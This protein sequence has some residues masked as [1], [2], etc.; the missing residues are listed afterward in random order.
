MP[1]AALV[2]SPKCWPF[3]ALL[4]R[5][6]P[7]VAA[8]V[9]LPVVA[10]GLPAPAAAQIPPPNVRV[11]ALPTVDNEPSVAVHGNHVVAV[12]YQGFYLNAAGWA[13][14]TDGGS[15]WIQRGDFPKGTN[16]QAY[17]L[18]S[19]SVGPDGM[20]HAA[21]LF[22]AVYPSGGGFYTVATFR[23]T[24]AGST[25]TW[26]GPVYAIPDQNTLAVDYDAPWIAS[27]PQ[28]GN[29]YLVYTRWYFDNSINGQS[30]YEIYLVRS[31]DGGLTWSAPQALS[32][33]NCNGARAM[34]GPDRELYVVW[35]DLAGEQ[36]VGRKSSDFGVTFGAPFVVAPLREN[37]GL[38]PPGG[39]TNLVRVNPVRR[40]QYCPSANFPALAVD[41]STGPRRGTLYAAWAEYG[42][43][44]VAPAT[45]SVSDPEPNDSFAS[46]ARV[47]IGQDFGG[48][49]KSSDIPPYEADVDIYT[50]D[51]IAGT[52]VWL[53]GEITGTDFLTYPYRTE[54]GFLWCGD[55]TTSLTEL[56][57]VGFKES[58]VGPSV[59]TI[60][61]L[62]RTGRY[63]LQLQCCGY[64]YRF[65]LRRYE[66]TP[67][68]A[69]RDQRDLVL[70]SSSDGG[71]TW[72]PKVRVNDDPPGFD[73]AFP[74]VA[75]DPRGAVHVAWY[76]HREVPGCG[77]A[78][79]VRLASSLDGG[80]TFGPSRRV[81][82]QPSVSQALRVGDH[83]ALEAVGDRLYVLWAQQ[84]R[85][86]VDVYS[87]VITDAV[88]ATLVQRFS[89][90]AEAD[91]VRVRWETLGGLDLAGFRLY[92][93]LREEGPY[94]PLE[95]TLQPYQGETRFE[96]EDRAV[97][98]GSAYWYR[99]EAVGRD[100]ASLWAGPISV[101]V[102]PVAGRLA[103]Q[104]TA[105]NPFELSVTM[106][107]AV[108]KAGEGWVRLYD[109]AGH[110]VA[111]LHRG[112]LPPGLHTF[113][114]GGTNTR[115][116]PTPAGI[117]LLR[118]EV[119]GEAATGKIVR[120]P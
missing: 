100:G 95:S 52:T 25:L 9:T 55:D 20:F 32:S 10:P 41:R 115:G 72:S 18:P 74:A 11:S 1:M 12:W 79:H 31:T 15:S 28:G 67:G 19:V 117:Y 97:E 76:D 14:S 82:E 111:T 61:T 50:F 93:A 112:P 114:W 4:D 47:E 53:Q 85:P 88:T 87:A 104:R 30:G 94:E 92:R 27:D 40:E 36:V 38:T 75:V 5:R 59:P 22:A 48:Y 62:P 73:D 44:T 90:A 119:A 83:L 23:G 3:L 84:G 35:Q 34:V 7:L 98:P 89:A 80:M 99:L 66:V 113:T 107:L 108:P 70:V 21:V 102:P 26:Q 45:G 56:A 91:R 51:G 81:S 54:L 42:V 105:P 57:C 29:L 49:M 120:V 8:L 13:L 116:E 68:Q 46:A 43:G 39:R 69:A 109:V 16:D 65:R 101:R 6:L 86:D 96:E 64:S 71:A 58:W 118:A 110:E 60:F 17:G 63:Y 106:T 33:T 2:P 103:W 37:L 78:V 24:V 77:T